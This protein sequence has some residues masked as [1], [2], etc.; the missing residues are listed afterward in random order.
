[1]A[2]GMV[3]ILRRKPNLK[4]NIMNIKKTLLSLFVAAAPVTVL[5]VTLN[6]SVPDG[7]KACFVAGKFNNWDADHAIALTR[8]DDNRFSIDLPDVSEAQITEGFKYLSGPGWKYVEKDAAGNEISNRTI[9]TDNDIVESWASLFNPDIITTTIHVNGYDRK[10]RIALPTDYATSGK[11]YP[12][13]YMTGVQQRYSA[14]GSDDAGDDFFGADSWNAAATAEALQK[15]GGEGCIL[16]ASYG[17][18]AENIP[19]ANPDFVGSG[20]SD[21]YLSDFITNIVGYVNANY[22]TIGTPA[23]T[24]IIGADLG[25]LFSLYAAMSRP[26]VFGKCVSISPMLWL[27]REEIAEMAGNAPD[28]LDFILSY[29]SRETGLIRDD[30]EALAS[31]LG[32]S[33]VCFQGGL[34]DDTSWGEAFPALYPFVSGAADAIPTEINL[35]R[36]SQRSAAPRQAADIVSSSYTFYYGAGS[37]DVEPDNT[38]SFNLI[39]NY[40]QKNGET[41]TARVLVKEIPKSVTNM[42]VYW[43]VARI[44]DDGSE[45]FLNSS[46][47]NVSFSTKKSNDSWLRVTIRSGESVEGVAAS[48]KGFN[49][50]TADDKILMTPGEGHTLSATVDFLDT[51]KSFTIHY[52]SVNSESDMGEIS[53][54]Y[55]VSE[56]CTQADIT[57]DF[58]SNAVAITETKWG[59]PIGQV[60]V[61]EFSATPAVAFPGQSSAISI[62]L[63]GVDGYVPSLLISHDYGSTSPVPV[64]E[65]ETGTWTA[66]VADLQEGIHTLTLDATISGSVVKDIAQI[67][68]RVVPSAAVS[69]QK[70]VTVNAYDDVDWASVG[71]Y[72][73]NFHTHTSQSF[74]TKF[75]TTHVVDAYANAGYKILAL[76]DHDANPYPWT[77]FDL[78]NPDAQSRSP[79]ELGML[80]IPGVELSKDNTNSWSEAGS[81][82]FNHHNDFFT[83]R[84][85]Q[86]FATL[87]ES[88]AYTDKLGGMQIINHPGQY[89]NI[90]T[91]YTPGSKNSPEWHAENFVT[92]PSLVGLEVYN[93]G[94]RRPNDRILWDQILQLTMPTRPV[95]GYSCDDTHTAEQYFRNYQF[96]LMPE[97]SID[98][99][100]DA[101]RQGCQYFSYEYTGSGEAKAPRITS[102]DVDNTKK[103]ITLESDGDEIYWIYGTDKP[104]NA[105]PGKRK[106]TVVGIGKTFNFDGYQGSYVRALIKNKFGETCTQPFGFTDGS[107]SSIE[108]IQTPAQNPSV[109]I[110]PNPASDN[111]SVSA[112]EDIETVE[113][114]NIS[115]VKVL[116]LDGCGTELNFN[117]SAFAHGY[118]IVKVDTVT[119]ST[120][121]KL[122]VR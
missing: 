5:A 15:N 9:A 12:V 1:M 114:Y 61:D 108:S 3:L 99:L 41:V 70:I 35:P 18:V 86:E 4:I 56:Y 40:T 65:S 47:K 55:S 97:L 58:D 106:S 103:I 91:D 105:A 81:G 27:N 50:V 102:I 52:G 60:H 23:S 33:P 89:W 25:G 110:S 26:E 73:A 119:T 64:T 19:F 121:L 10:V 74:D 85:G 30:V 39:D 92:Y 62:R 101:M 16:V 8:I 95:W 107:H 98:A 51:D 78:F 49:V 72:K 79:E 45:T 84:K 28:G 94:N 122:I 77:L 42:K 115:G 100:K 113:V 109:S 38:V 14:A 82:D 32:T 116:S 63:R 36:S 11:S 7:T 83:G 37:S 75:N 111:V 21:A 117:V 93:Q 48:S 31:I 90:D 53:A 57:Y 88:Y 20:D 118:Y 22:R 69:G 34:H 80:A 120:S 17:F 2:D 43:N 24:T 59:E 96:M 66:S 112:S 44:N 46:V 87:R 54:T 6:V 104:D 68:I 76:T 67:C 29:G 71:R 13:A